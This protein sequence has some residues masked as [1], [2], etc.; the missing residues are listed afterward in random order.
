TNKTNLKESDLEE[1]VNKLKNFPSKYETVRKF[2]VNLDS[3]LEEVRAASL[4]RFEWVDGLLVKAVQQGKWLVLD[5][6]NL[7]SASVLDRLNSLLEPNG[8]LIIN[9]HSGPDGQPR[10]VKPHPNFRL[11]LTMD[12]RNGELSRAM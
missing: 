3:A 7:C 12:P 6:A 10:L 5:N 4:A 9:E 8:F 2:R 1:L 11:F